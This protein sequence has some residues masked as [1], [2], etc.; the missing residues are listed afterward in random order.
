MNFIN[1]WK[2]TFEL[3]GQ[4]DPKSFMAVV[5]EWRGIL[6]LLL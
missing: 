1:V 2:S 5:V 3:K 4:E 6:A